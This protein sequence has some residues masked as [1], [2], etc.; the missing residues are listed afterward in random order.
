MPQH[1]EF[2]TPS[3]VDALM[4]NF[5]EAARVAL[6]VRD[7]AVPEVKDV[8]LQPPCSS[9]DSPLI[10]ELPLPPPP[11]PSFQHLENSRESALCG[12]FFVLDPNWFATQHLYTGI[13][14][15]R[16]GGVSSNQEFGRVSR[17]LPECSGTRLQESITA[18]LHEP[19]SSIQL[20]TANVPKRFPAPGSSGKL[21]PAMCRS[22]TVA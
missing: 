7:Q 15:K 14:T 10:L 16:P 18:L 20:P 22:A 17:L 8:Q 1:T 12:A 21:P 9:A 2:L 13:A 5:D 11:T 4:A 3:F 19:D 6:V